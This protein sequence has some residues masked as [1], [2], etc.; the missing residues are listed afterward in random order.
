M[1][2]VRQYITLPKAYDLS[3]KATVYPLKAFSNSN[4]GGNAQKPQFKVNLI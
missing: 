2:T 1:S 3:P 4:N